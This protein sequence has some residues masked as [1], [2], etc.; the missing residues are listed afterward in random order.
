RKGENST[1]NLHN[2]EENH[3]LGA[4]LGQVGSSYIV[5]TTAGGDL[6][7][8]DQH[9]AHE[10]L[11][12]ER[13]KEQLN[14]GFI[15]AQPLLI[16][17]PVTLPRHTLTAALDA[18]NLLKKWGLEVESHT[19]T[20]L[21]VT[22]TPA[23][24]GDVNPAPILKEVSESIEENAN[25][26]SVQ[27]ALERVLSTYACHHSVRAGRRLSL[28]EQNQ[29]LRDIENTPAA[30]TCNHGRPTVRL[31]GALQLATLFDR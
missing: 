29:L 2:S 7:L 26:G 20:S 10:R 14:Q 13:L 18:A 5:A 12:Y 27:K 24:L 23:I 17:T 3:P 28:S 6:V 25:R 31:L 4:A 11:V 21:M 1:E 30:A 9:A 19:E 22:A 15:Q 8:V 16:P